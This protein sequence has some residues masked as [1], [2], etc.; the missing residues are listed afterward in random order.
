MWFNERKQTKEINRKT[1]SRKASIDLITL[2]Y[3]NANFK[4]INYS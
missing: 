4:G 2:A 3:K 1:F